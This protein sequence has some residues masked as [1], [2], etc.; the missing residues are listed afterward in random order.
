M[1]VTLPF[2]PKELNPNSRLHF[3]KVARIKKRYRQTCWALAKEA[4]FN[5]T[6][7]A[8]CEAASVHL[9][10]Y[11]P[12]RRHRDQDNMLAAMKSALDGLAEAL[13]FND[14]GFKVT[15]DVSDDIGSKVVVSIT[16]IGGVA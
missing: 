11:P 2:P 12:D 4:G 10:F 14:R 16:G 9:S 8:G 7:L 6:S 1:H 3:M 15:F 13:H 5:S